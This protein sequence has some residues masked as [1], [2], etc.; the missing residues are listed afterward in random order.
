MSKIVTKTLIPNDSGLVNAADILKSGGILAFPTETVYGLGADATSDTAIARIYSA[1]KRPNFNPLIVHFSDLSVAKNHVLWPEA[2]E[3]LARAF[4][5]GALTF[6][7]KKKANSSL[8]L[9][10][11]AGLPSIAIRI[12]DH[13]IAHRLLNI[14]DRPIAAP[15]A[16]LSGTI[17]PTSAKHVLNG[18]EGV[19]EGIIDGGNCKLG[20]ESTI[21]DLTN[22]PTLLRPGSVTVSAIEQELGEKLMSS[23][24]NSGIKAP[25]QLSS[26][27]A[28]RASV[29]LNATD[30]MS[31]EVL[32]GF[33]PMVCDL[34]LSPTSNLTEAAANLF[35]Y[36]HKLDNGQS[37]QIAVASIPAIDLGLAINDRL[38]RAAAPRNENS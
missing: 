24:S 10:L 16:N 4:W 7:L 38:E 15:S 6:V 30:K 32:L 8:S 19:I 28:P 18:L 34:N 14:F 20:L 37:S 26:H 36:L 11:N 21:V 35:A 29:R 27:Y 31:G 23:G 2:A 1:K 3:K 5:P 13:P 25:G 33:G 9:L 17:S 12:P 22:Y